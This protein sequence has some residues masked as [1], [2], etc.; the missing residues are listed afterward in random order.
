MKI[1]MTAPTALFGLLSLGLSMTAWLPGSWAAV[2]GY[3]ASELRSVETSDE[4]KIRELRQQEVTQLRIALGRRSPNNRRADLYLRLA[5]IYLEAY[6]ADY[7]LEGRVHEKRLEKGQPDRLIDHSH[8]R[9]SLGLGIQACKEILSF[10][11]PYAK[12][13]QVYYFLG[14]NYSEMGDRT[15]SVR[16]FDQLARQY[17]QSPYVGEAYKELGDESFEH[18]QFK[19]A[20]SYYEMAAKQ[21]NTETLPHVYHKL[22]WSYY[23][24]R[25]YDSAV[26]T[27]RL[28]ISSAQKSGEKFL[29]LREEALRDMAIFMTETGK[30]EEAIQYFGEVSNDKQFFPKILE[31]LGKQ[32][33]RNVEPAKATQVYESLLKTHPNTEAGF[34]VRVKLVDL[35]L[36]QR[37]F[38][39]A[40][41]RLNGVEIPKTGEN[42]TVVAAQNLRAM[43]RR[44]ATEHHE[45]YRKSANR[46]DLLIAESYYGAYLNLF[47]RSED[48]RNETP[49]IRMYLA[50]VKRELGYSRDASQLYRLVVESKDKRY[51]KEAGALW[52]ASL[53][54]AI[55]RAA[56]GG[57]GT[58]G[59]DPSALELEF[60]DAADRLADAMGEANEGRESALR[61]AEVLAGYKNTQKNT[62]KRLQAILARW[63]R[64][65]Q[66]LTAAK[67]WLQLGSEGDTEGLRETLKLI[68]ASD[69]L[70]A[71]DAENG[72]KLR[73][74]LSD[75]EVRLKIGTIAQEEKNNDF[76]GAGRSYEAFAGETTDH[77]LAEKAYG[78]AL[79][80]FL[81]VGD[82]ESIDRVSGRWLQRYPKNAGAVEAIRSAATQLLIAGKFETTGKLF[83][84]LGRDAGD[85]ESLE[86]AAR[87]FEAAGDRAH[88][89]QLWV[90]FLERFPTHAHRPAVALV[91]GRSQDQARLDPQAA[92]AYKNC[93]NGPYAFQAECGARLGDLYA[94]ILDWSQ[95]KAQYHKVAALGA[96]APAVL[97]KQP[98]LKKQKKLKKNAKNGRA[99]AAAPVHASGAS[100]VISPYVGYA[101]YRLA[102][103]METETKFDRLEMPEAQ[104]KKA[105]QQRM[106]FLEP[107]SRAYVS[108]VDAGGPWAVAALARLAN[109]AVN[110]ADEVDH[111][112]PPAAAD[113]DAVTRFRANLAGVSAPL[114]KKAVTTWAEGYA[115]ALANET[116]SPALPEL[117]DHLAS[118]TESRPRAQ[119]YRGHFRLAGIAAD[120]GDLGKVVAFEKVRERLGK[121]P[122][123]GGAWVDYGNL[124]WG[125]GRPEAARI[126]YDRALSLNSR[127]PG[128]LNNRAVVLLS[129]EGEENWS[130]ASEANALFRE[131]IA[132]DEFFLPAKMNRAAVLNYF[133]LFERAK[134]L[135]DQVLTRSQP[136]DAY[137][138]QG[139]ALQGLGQNEAA[140]AAFQHAREAGAVASR[141]A[142]IFHEAARTKSCASR[143]SDL[144]FGQLV[145][146]ER[147]SAERLRDFC[148]GGGSK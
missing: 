31:R 131:A 3:Q 120:G 5:E 17:P 90:S 19:K 63:P 110:F 108:A 55:R 71:F 81:K 8:S 143:I 48:P 88:A 33:E 37:H 87:V 60:V 30:V 59:T 121:N 61:A 77:N 103:L 53:S 49:E 104:L 118:S 64:S 45:K 72:G 86:T 102:E 54:E 76:A 101:R 27:M 73:A 113:P 132:Q 148:A 99:Q 127:I 13:D 138:G 96:Q 119:G 21:G 44:T 39:E 123:D 141:F 142:G 62:V 80:S 112:A 126:A 78:N 125:E 114:R 26:Q 7:I 135:W 65:S 107:L 116:L 28:A 22:A 36:R 12:V 56:K 2:G 40:L 83:E 51:A 18:G 35:D 97:E 91:L 41:V 11:I 23:R 93:M 117:A 136:A 34:R 66:A 58:K 16:Y 74:Q 146:F 137:D 20:Q 69:A 85:P 79:T 100:I 6:R 128:A 115:K 14:F 43:I 94:R 140:I 29:S 10:R 50:E 109:W 134:P 15:Q 145:G 89:Q 124:L 68:R 4:G 98:K 92:A 46:A 106:D 52:T 147:E 144:N 84:R 57:V 95:A 42:E 47:L 67:L 32:Y 130:A 122:Q 38:K 24:T 9:P 133:R 75:Q 111:I 139:I 70:L 1:R 105:L 82:A 25:Q 129:V